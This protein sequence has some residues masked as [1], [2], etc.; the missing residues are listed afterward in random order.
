MKLSFLPLLL[1]TVCTSQA[2]LSLMTYN[3]RYPTPNDGADWWEYRKTE[4]AEML[5]Y[6]QPDVLGI[7]EG[8]DAQVRFLDS[9]LVDYDYV[10]VGRDDG[11]RGGEFSAIFYRRDRLTVLRHQTHWLSETP[12]RVSVG[13]DAAM[14]RIVTAAELLDRE[15]GDTLLVFNA[16]FDHIGPLARKNSAKLMVRLASEWNPR[17]HP[18][19]LMGDFNAEPGSAPIRVFTATFSDAFD[20]AELPSYGS[21]GTFTGFNVEQPQDRRLDYIFVKNCSV[22]RH[23]HLDDRRRNGRFLSDHLPVLVHLK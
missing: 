11:Q 8:V 12:D 5:N 16:H 7:Q 2:Q 22:A 21:P 23:R 13:W 6:Y 4:V 17:N 18:V 14:E 9:A 1:L 19:I 20:S 10:G 15:R 3:L